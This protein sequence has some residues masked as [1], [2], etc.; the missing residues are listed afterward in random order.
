M[1]IKKHQRFLSIILAVI[2]MLSI[3]P[4]GVFTLKANALSFSPRTTCPERNNP[5]YYSNINP[6]YASGY[7]M[8]NCT[9]YAFGR[10]YEVLG[11]RPNLC[12]GNAGTW[13]SYNKNHGYYSYS[14]DTPKAGSIV[15]W[16]GHVAFVESV[17][18]NGTINFSE[19][20]WSARY[21]GNEYKYF[22]YQTNINPHNYAG[23]LQG[24]I[25]VVPND[26]PKPPIPSSPTGL[27]VDA[28]NLAQKKIVRFSWNASS[29]AT[30]YK[31]AVR[32]AETKNDIDVGNK[33]YYDCTLNNAGKY[34]FYVKA[35]NSTGSSNYSSEYKSC[36]SHAPVTVTFV[37]YDGREISKQ[38]IDYGTSAKAPA[39]APSREGYTFN[40]WSG[41]Y[42]NVTQNKTITATYKIITYTVN[43][44]DKE[45]N[46]IVERKVDYH[47]DADPPADTHT[48]AGYE[49]MGWS[50]EAY[51]NVFTTAANKTINVK[52]IYKYINENLPIICTIKSVNCQSEG[53]DVSLSLSNYDK[54]STT[55]R[56]VVALKTASGKLVDMTESDAFSITR[57]GTKELTVFVPSKNSGSKI[58]VIIVDNYSTGI[59][60][61]ASK[62][63]DI[64][65]QKRWTQWDVY[66]NE[67]ELN[68]YNTPGTEFDYKTQYRY[69]DY[70]F[71]TGST[72]T[73][74]SA[75]NEPSWEKTGRT[76]K[77]IKDWTNY[78]WDF[79]QGYDNA[80]GRREVDDTH[81]AIYSYN[82]KTQW[83][84]NRW[85]G[86]YNRSRRYGPTEGSISL[87]YNR[88]YQENGWLDYPLGANG[89]SSTGAQIYGDYWYNQSTRSV[90]SGEN[91]KKQYRYREFQYVYHFKRL[92]FNWTEWSDEKVTP[93]ADK[94][95]V[96][97][98]KM[99]RY[100]NSSQ[101]KENDSGKLYNLNDYITP[102]L[103]SA[104][105]GKQI[106]VFVVKYGEASDFTNEFIG[107]TTVQSNGSYNIGSFK[108]REEPT[109]KTGDFTI[110][111]AI[112]GTSDLVEVGKIPAPI[113]E[114]KVVYYAGDDST[115]LSEQTVREGESAEVPESPEKEGY[116]FIGWD[117]SNINVK[118]D[119]E[120]YPMF[121][122]KEY[123]V[124]FVDWGNQTVE[125]RK[126]EHGDVL[127]APNHSEVEGYNFDGWDAISDGTF[128]VTQDMVVTA[129]YAKK[130]Y[131]VRFYDFDNN[132]IS[133]QSVEFQEDAVAPSEIGESEDG[134]KFIGWQDID[135]LDVDGDAYVYP[136]YYYE[137]TADAPAA[138]YESGEYS[139][140][141]ELTL[142]PGDENDVMYYI[143][144]SN[145]EEEIPYTGP[146]TVD[147]TCSITF[148]ATGFGKN[149]SEKI[150]NYYCINNANNMSEWMKTAD[151]PAD[152]TENA[153]RY[154]IESANGYR[155]KDITTTSSSSELAALLGDGW[156]FISYSDYTSEPQEE[157]IPQDNDKINFEIITDGGPEVDNN[158]NAHHYMHYKYTDSTGTVS[159]SRN[160]NPSY[161]CVLE[162]LIVPLSADLVFSGFENDDFNKPIYK[163][164]NGIEWFNQEGWFVQYSCKYKIASLY[165]WTEWT[166][167][168][169]SSGESREYET[170]GLSRYANKNYHVVTVNTVEDYPV[171]MF[172]QDGLRIDTTELNSIYGY[173]YKGLY[174]DNNYT[175][176][177][178]ETTPITES[179]ELYAK[180][181]LHKFVVK[182]TL[183]NGQELCPRQNVEYLSA[184]TDP[185]AVEVT[186]YV[187]G[188]WDKDFS[189]ITENTTV[190]GRYYKES[191]YARISLNRSSFSMFTG[192]YFDLIPTINPNPNFD[193][194]VE[195][196]SSNPSVALVD[197]NG[198]VIAM[199]AGTAVIKAKL[200]ENNEYAL[201]TV[202]VQADL[203]AKLFLKENSKLNYDD[204]GYIRRVPLKTSVSAVKDEFINTSLAFEN[205]DGTVLDDSDYVGTGTV[206]K[207]MDGMSVS[208]SKTFIVTGDN[209]GNGR[210]NLADS[211]HIMCYILE[212]EEFT[213][214][215]IGASDV[216]G[217]GKV[218][219]KDA[220]L[221]AKFVAGLEDINN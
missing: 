218:N 155:Y 115:I 151:L 75:A 164:E 64:S 142:T 116:T 98:R 91:W 70:E 97:T 23:T 47:N 219:N 35:Y 199:Q 146:I 26:P 69:K 198:K 88:T 30:G 204:L 156:T 207:L 145:P 159:Y 131:T 6:F 182:F 136:A 94:R 127:E 57:N 74:S 138:N 83:L 112:E 217:D 106:T 137:D 193:K 43:F 66:E 173:D 121:V 208:D 76:E 161:N 16:S 214:C 68:Q 205:M 108:L 44:L 41:S 178:A 135:Y 1:K 157:E 32:G 202:T 162:E 189:C 130:E 73:K 12:T 82:Y 111:I 110:A 55:G 194:E 149:D 195:W 33:L 100:N 179:I 89:I 119:M 143:L 28:E 203:Y 102:K 5:Y 200:V 185:G 2:M 78:S 152:V 4:T 52:G 104:F 129:Q 122:K 59:P 51:K 20:N 118:E 21:S 201:C 147:K 11:T 56:A 220:A 167:D 211:S 93:I 24:Y 39:E 40:G 114:Y 186:G 172:V 95:V 61:S 191:E 49:F 48:P 46:T 171:K 71:S 109:V 15:C 141:I 29:G 60:I 7:G 38:T 126:F 209:D 170:A 192:T 63:F 107:Q 45:G 67:S 79:V 184:A 113:P 133:I 124:V 92:P 187:F 180:Y 128:V 25:Y 158:G 27:R 216:T 96:D 221:I 85:T 197:N 87:C 117:K 19:S 163:D 86:L 210:C 213:T 153:D 206:V 169:P 188:G 190:I 165:K 148:F 90:V 132:V 160:E 53:Y 196:S 84:Y 105:A 18:S 166:T 215:Q 37:D 140:S 42:Y 58:E 34:Q 22:R 154:V 175:Q 120:I 174:R 134:K 181:T 101:I 13:Y 103:S 77:L 81:S 54:G 36:T 62:T 125:T 168:A 123:T 9:C 72:T 50:S 31:V 65:G 212:K 177:F 99:F 8:P 176:S 14:S 10:A 139:D 150:T 80:S 17:N 3:I 144:S 183:P